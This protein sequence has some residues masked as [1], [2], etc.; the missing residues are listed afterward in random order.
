MSVLMLVVLGVYNGS[1]CCPGAFDTCVGRLASLSCV[2]K[3]RTW[4]PRLNHTLHRHHRN[5]RCLLAG[6]P[7]LYSG[8]YRRGLAAYR[9]TVNA[10]ARSDGFPSRETMQNLEQCSPPPDYPHRVSVLLFC[11]NITQTAPSF[12]THSSPLSC[13]FTT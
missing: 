3:D 13:R 1:R 5:Q 4:L 10:C 9:A 11:H 7:S 6:L 12:Q 8:E 2:M